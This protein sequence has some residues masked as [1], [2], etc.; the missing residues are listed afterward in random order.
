MQILEWSLFQSFMT[1]NK[2]F[3]KKSVVQGKAMYKEINH[4]YIHEDFM[5]QEAWRNSLHLFEV[6]LKEH[7][8]NYF[9]LM[10]CCGI[11][12]SLLFYHL[13]F[14]RAKFF[15]TVSANFGRRD[16]KRVMVLC[17]PKKCRK[18]YTWS[19]LTLGKCAVKYKN[20]MVIFPFLVFDWKYPFWPNL[21]KKNQN[22]EFKLKFSI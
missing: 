14:P 19:V 15:I 6:S 22:C 4:W 5:W 2:E 21:V 12:T 8:L 16:A 9:S 17:N 13:S 11:N 3:L 20:S 10:Y 18:I 1:W 7:L